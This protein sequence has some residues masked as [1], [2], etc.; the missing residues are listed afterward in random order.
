MLALQEETAKL[1]AKVR[2]LEEELKIVGWYAS[3]MEDGIDT[4]QLVGDY[5]V[6][7]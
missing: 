4:K 7:K 5:C 3:I 6:L 2:Q 1:S